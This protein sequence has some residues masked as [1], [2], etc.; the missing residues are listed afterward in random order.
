[1]SVASLRIE[2]STPF[3]ESGIPRRGPADVAAA[4]ALLDNP[5]GTR[6]WGE[7]RLDGVGIRLPIE[8]KGTELLVCI[9]SATRIW[10]GGAGGGM[11]LAS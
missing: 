2:D 1:M 8:G 10:A 3:G 4:H 9:R 6:E 5:S 11:V 7:A